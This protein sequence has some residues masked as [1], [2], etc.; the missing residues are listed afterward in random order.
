[1]KKKM[2]INQLFSAALPWIWIHQITHWIIHYCQALF[3]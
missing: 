3:S 1:M 2:I